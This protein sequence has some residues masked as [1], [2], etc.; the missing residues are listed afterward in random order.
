ME[1]PLESV[2]QLIA[3][4]TATQAAPEEK[5]EAF[6]ELVGAFQD[7]AYGCAYAILGDAH[8]AEDAAQEAFITAWREIGKLEHPQAFPAW[9]KRIVLTQCNR[10]TRR[11][12]VD[13]VVLES[14]ASEAAGS[15]PGDPAIV[16]ERG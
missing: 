4:V 16:V 12:R 13:T 10:L 11:K 8:L 2:D 5:A 14:A 1:V 7:M 6:A 15:T 9:F 3:R